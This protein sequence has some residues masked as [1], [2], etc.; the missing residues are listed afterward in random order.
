MHPVVRRCARDRANILIVLARAQEKEGAYITARDIVGELVKLLADGVG[1]ESL[2][3]NVSLAQARWWLTH[4]ERLTALPE[5][6][7]K[8]FREA[9]AQIDQHGKEYSGTDRD[10]IQAALDKLERARENLRQLLG[11]TDYRYAM[12]GLGSQGLNIRMYRFDRLEAAARRFLAD[13]ERH[14]MQRDQLYASTLSLAASCA[15]ARGDISRAGR[16]YQTALDILQV[17][18]GKDAIR[19]LNTQER[20]ADWYVNLGDRQRASQLYTGLAL[21][22]KRRVL[23]EAAR[24]D[25]ALPF[26]EDL[27]GGSPENQLRYATV[28]LKLVTLETRPREVNPRREKAHLQYVAAVRRVRGENHPDHVGALLDLASY[29]HEANNLARFDEYVTRARGALAKAGEVTKGLEATLDLA[30]GLVAQEKGEYATAVSHLRRA[31]ELRK[32]I[33]GE[34]SRDYWITLA[35]LA[36]ALQGVGQTV[37]AVSVVEQVLAAQKKSFRH[38]YNAASPEIAQRYLDSSE[39]LY[40]LLTLDS[41]VSM[42]VK[43]KP[44]AAQVERLWSWVLRCKGVLLDAQCRSREAQL[45]T[46]ADANLARQ[47]QR[48]RGIQENVARLAAQPPAGISP[49]QLQRDRQR[50]RDE[51]TRLKGELDKELARRH[52]EQFSSDDKLSLA[53]LRKRL[54]DRAVLVEFILYAPIH[55]QPQGDKKL[56]KP[57]YLA[58]ALPA[59][60]DSVPRLFDLGPAEDIDDA[61]LA[62]R[63]RLERF[64][65][66]LK[67]SSGEKSVEDDFRKAAATLYEKL[68]GPMREVLSNCTE[69]VLVP[70]NTLHLLPFAALVDNKGRYLIETHRLGYLSA[71]RDMLRPAP[72]RKGSGVVVFAGPDFD[73]GSAPRLEKVKPLLGQGLPGIRGPEGRGEG[74]SWKPLK[75]A[76]L[77]ADDIE[78]V[79]KGGRLGAVQVYKGPDALEERLKRVASPRIL[80]LATHG[81]FY[82]RRAEEGRGGLQERLETS[83]NPLLRSGIVLAGA[84]AWREKLPDGARLEDGWVT[85]EEAALL[86]LSGTDLVVLSACESGLGDVQSSEGVYGLR[87]SFLYAGARSVVTSLFSVPDQDTRPLMKSFYEGLAEGRGKLEALHEAQRKALEARRKQHGAAHPFYWAGFI[88]VGEP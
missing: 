77:E 61:V 67:L 9:I 11:E 45:A 13:M 73:L 2:A 20:L 63:R 50:L 14:G 19:T 3:P 17:A 6:Q 27:T 23:G 82:Q 33:H 16:D 43:E 36:W 56:V 8:Q 7:Q 35:N 86:Q 29:Y 57:R 51:A 10:Q 53:Q 79:L 24:G 12:S 75:G 37:E 21:A 74:L 88:L 46:A 44:K 34:D 76:E 38:V 47:V 15:K 68:F 71:G 25:A 40:G 69:V 41:L 70:D 22:W 80:H 30:L 5:G 62:L 52:P 18:A 28:F 60:P 83:A 49:Q 65:D 58:L 78:A 26:G 84:N 54:P 1:Q 72:A 85:A 81:F 39:G 48:L 42:I 59:G 32:E 4:L 87:R 64:R 55:F 66:D 31:T